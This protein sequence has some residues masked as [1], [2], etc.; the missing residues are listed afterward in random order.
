MKVQTRLQTVDE[1]YSNIDPEGAF[2]YQKHLDFVE[3]KKQKKKIQSAK[4]DH[5]LPTLAEKQERQKQ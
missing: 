1:R 4:M 5:M 3:K 2:I